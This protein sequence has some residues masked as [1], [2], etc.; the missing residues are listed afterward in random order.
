MLD[1]WAIKDDFFAFRLDKDTRITCS[2]LNILHLIGI[3]L[4]FPLKLAIISCW[5]NGICACDSLR[6]TMSDLL[7]SIY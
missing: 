1:C 2:K 4:C 3:K 5:E 6:C 7:H